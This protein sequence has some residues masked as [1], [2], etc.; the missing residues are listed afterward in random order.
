VKDDMKLA[1]GL[2]G[3]LALLLIGFYLDDPKWAIECAWFIWFFGM[4]LPYKAVILYP[5]YVIAILAVGYVIPDRW[6]Q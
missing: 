3:G 6:C 4:Y 2:V 5:H 1:A